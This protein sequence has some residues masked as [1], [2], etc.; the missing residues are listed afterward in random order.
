MAVSLLWPLGLGLGA[1]LAFG[2][3]KKS[4]TATATPLEPITP[5]SGPSGEPAFGTM[6]VTVNRPG[7]GAPVVV[8]SPRSEPVV[9]ERETVPIGP[10]VSRQKL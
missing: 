4:S 9:N 6:P 8:S 2:S 7:L 5:V 3:K 1:L 10:I